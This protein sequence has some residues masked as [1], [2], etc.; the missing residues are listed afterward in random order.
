MQSGMVADPLSAGRTAG[1]REM[2]VAQLT[3]PQCFSFVAR[4]PSCK[5]R[6]MA[7]RA[8]ATGLAGAHGGLRVAASEKGWAQWITAWSAILQLLL[9]VRVEPARQSWRGGKWFRRG[10]IGD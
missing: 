9:L 4:A 2:C 7:V 10:L 3:D 6:L 8:A 1:T 5:S